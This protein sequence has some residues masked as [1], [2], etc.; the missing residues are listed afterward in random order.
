[1]A[2]ITT[3]NNGESRLRHSVR[4]PL[5]PAQAQDNAAASSSSHDEIS[6]CWW[7]QLSW[8]ISVLQRPALNLKVP[9]FSNLSPVNPQPARYPFE[10]CQWSRHF[11]PDCCLWRS[12]AK[13][14]QGDSTGALLITTCCHV[15]Y[16]AFISS[17]FNCS[18]FKRVQ[19]CCLKKKRETC[20]F[21]HSSVCL[22]HHNYIC[23]N[24]IFFFIF[25]S[26]Q[27]VNH[28]SNFHFH[29]FRFFLPSS[30]FHT[31]LKV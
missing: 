15:V 23:S 24:V 2:G 4:T 11:S 5:H 27:P 12:L 3:R 28:N 17:V 16:S 14:P 25:T 21:Y 19:L 26:K 7:C 18:V 10:F 29:T 30:E 22:L 31:T 1:M 13:S 9:H 6:F 20:S 8:L